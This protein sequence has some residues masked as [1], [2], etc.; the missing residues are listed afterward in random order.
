MSL[1]GNVCHVISPVASSDSAADKQDT[2]DLS[3]NASGSNVA[4][5]IIGA[6]DTPRKLATDLN[7]NLRPASPQTPH[8]LSFHHRILKFASADV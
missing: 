7:N 5:T 4:H 2:L 8:G 3:I 1:S 6:P